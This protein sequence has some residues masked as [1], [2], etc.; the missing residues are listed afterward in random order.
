EVDNYPANVMVLPALWPPKRNAQNATTKGR[1][2]SRTSLTVQSSASRA[3]IYLTPEMVDFE[4]RFT[5]KFNARDYNFT[6]QPSNA[7]LLED[8]RTRGDRLHPFWQKVAV[9]R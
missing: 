5:V 3:T 2:N 1:I 7:V 9:G 4:S 8:A 6:V